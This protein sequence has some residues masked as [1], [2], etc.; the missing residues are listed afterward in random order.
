MRTVRCSV[1]MSLDGCIADPQGG[2]DWIVIDPEIDFEASAG[3]ETVA[4]EIAER[5][6]MLD[7][8]CGIGSGT[9]RR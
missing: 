9:S 6:R 3:L 8:W 2:Y 7:C 4:A 5:V 1:A